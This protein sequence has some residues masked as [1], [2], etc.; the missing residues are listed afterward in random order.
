MTK[1]LYQR[2]SQKVIPAG[3]VWSIIALF[4]LGVAFLGGSSRADVVQ[5]AALRPFAALMLIPALYLIS[6]DAA[7]PARTVLFLFGALIAWTSIQLI[8]LPAWLWQSLPGRDAVVELD[9]LAGQAD[10]WRPI[11]MVPARGI[12]ALIA[13]L[14]PIT[15][16]ALVLALR[17]KVKDI[18]LLIVALGIVDALL[19]FLQLMTGAS[20]PLYFYAITNFGSAVGILANENHS[21]VFSSLVMLVSVRLFMDATWNREGP[22]LKI[23]GAAGFFLGLLAVLAS[24]SRAGFLTGLLAL[25]ACVVMLYLFASKSASDKKS[26]RASRAQKPKSIKLGRFES[27]LLADPRKI[28]AIAAFAIIVLAALF[29]LSGRAAGLEAAINKDP[30][31][32]L[33]WGLLPVLGAMAGEHWLLGTGFGSF[34]EV[35]H[36]YE[37]TELLRSTYIN[38]AHNDWAQLIIEGGLPATLI[39]VGLL[40]W[41]AKRLLLT[42]RTLEHGK[43]KTVFWLA[44]IGVIAAGSLPDYPLR[45]PL[46]QV[47]YVWLILA[48]AIETKV[49]QT[50]ATAR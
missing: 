48:L 11:S 16:I 9:S 37:P 50:N 10:I 17:L 25:G 39:L 29:V 36:I 5:I 27:Q 31:D 47:V 45:T 26:G 15:A 35:Y 34:D 4:A 20:S 14:V 46:F 32:D 33:R 49:R 6:S 40:V 30:F 12:N 42:L 21:A 3:F 24:G 19:G 8:P 43:A 23:V 18:F 38:Q 7:R 41:I 2:T 22:W 13:L 28:A 44:A 1:T